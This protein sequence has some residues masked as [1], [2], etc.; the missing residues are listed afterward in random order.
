MSSRIT[1]V[2]PL[3]LGLAAPAQAQ[4]WPTPPPTAQ[5]S[6]A[7]PVDKVESIP[8]ARAAAQKAVWAGTTHWQVWHQGDPADSLYRV[9]YGFFTKQEYRAAADRF[10]D[11]RARFPNSRYACDA[12]YFEA[13]ARY[14]LGTPNDL[15]TA[16]RLL[17]S[18]GGNCTSA[19]R[20][21]DVPELLA[22]VNSA[23]ARQGDAEAAERM[24]R[25]ASQGQ[26][27][28]DREE[29]NVKIEALSA[30]AQME[31]AEANPVLRS[32]LATRDECAAPVRRQA[33][34]LVARR[35]DAEAATLL[36]TVARSD[37]NA[38]NQMEAVRALG[39]M[40]N[41]R[42]FSA[43]EEILRE[44]GEERVRMSV[45]S[46]MA[47]S[48]QA[49]AQAAVRALVERRDVSERIRLAGIE[50]LAGRPD[51]SLDYWRALYTR[52]DSEALRKAVIAAIA[53]SGGEEGKDFLL[54]LARTPSEPYA[55]RE[56]A[57]AR[58]RGTAPVN[59]LYEL[60][61]T[62]DSRSMRMSIVSALYARKEPE[63]TDRLIDIAKTSTDPEIRAAAIR[64]LGQD[65]RKS[66]PK[67]IR[68]LGE[69]LGCCQP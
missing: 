32:V 9:A 46:A 24:R 58:I 4:V 16:Y 47:R 15:R 49:R 62:A 6:F 10:S 42:A 48:E 35:D 13:F 45:V 39:R 19:E 23:Q 56:S 65:P 53:K 28:C 69:I 68:A 25:A 63:A 7:W 30:L 14:R 34:R 55:L 59:Q 67:V 11:V 22:R 3:L 26:N 17:D 41:E 64:A 36:A 44:P 27:V 33:V 57:V 21:R 51:F 20:R 61:Q 43:L 40:S 12:T 8:V 18:S 31:P 2:L 66:D 29:R 1:L 52:L 60:L 37:P 50:G 54:G 38:E 5:K